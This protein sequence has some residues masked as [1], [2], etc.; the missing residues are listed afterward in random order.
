M[1]ALLFTVLTN[2]LCFSCTSSLCA[3]FL[4]VQSNSSNHHHQNGQY[5]TMSGGVTS[6]MP[7]P[8]PSVVAKVPECTD[9]ETR[10]SMSGD[11]GIDTNGGMVLNSNTNTHLDYYE[12]SLY[13]EFTLK[14]Q[15]Q[16]INHP[17]SISMEGSNGSANTS[18]QS[19]FP[20][21]SSSSSIYTNNG[22]AAYRNY[23]HANSIASPPNINTF[24]QLQTPS[25]N[26]SLQHPTAQ[27]V[28][29]RHNYVQKSTLQLTQQTISNISS[30]N[31]RT[32]ELGD[33]VGSLAALDGLTDLLPMMPTSEAVKLSLR[34]IEGVDD[35][36]N[37]EQP[38]NKPLINNNSLVLI[39]S[40]PT[41]PNPS[42]NGSNCSL[43]LK[44]WDESGSVAS[45]HSSAFSSS[46]TPPPLNPSTSLYHLQPLKPLYQQQ[47]AVTK[48]TGTTINQI[49]QPGS[50]SQHNHSSHLEFPCSAPEVTNLLLSDFGVSVSN[51][52]AEWLDNLIKL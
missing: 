49:F 19:R 5:Y 48:F 43:A 47:E 45:S 23:S 40:S 17:R 30:G 44:N 38:E 52:D 42:T 25:F 16:H 1:Y 11:F 6:Y 36:S 27:N 28:S 46:E 12:R 51:S 14:H 50:S 9:I 21:T 37:D 41:S 15:Q 35:D 26:E 31:H 3:S 18:S 22:R 10:I 4:L 7:S 20:P 2:F 24:H 33:E 8:V 13:D 29:N 34:D 39:G 32:T